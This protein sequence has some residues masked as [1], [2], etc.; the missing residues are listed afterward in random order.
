MIPFVH[1]RGHKGQCSQPINS[2]ADN[3]N[4][5][6]ISYNKVGSVHNRPIILYIKV[7]SV[8][9]SQSWCSRANINRPISSQTSWVNRWRTETMNWCQSS[10]LCRWP[11]STPR[12]PIIGRQSVTANKYTHINSAVP[13]GTL[14]TAVALFKH[15]WVTV[16][17][18]VNRLGKLSLPSLRGR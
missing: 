17:G 4:R 5:P 16:C 15:R 18:R 10:V 2:A 14:W 6:I 12:S 8:R 11:S 7:G 3:I 1:R 13:S 9:G